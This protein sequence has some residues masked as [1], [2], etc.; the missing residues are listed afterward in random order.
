M[1]FFEQ[2]TTD[3]K[4]KLYIAHIQKNTGHIQTVKQH[5]EHVAQ[6]AQKFACEPLKEIAYTGGLL[7]DVGKYQKSFQQKIVG[8]QNLQVDH[9]TCGA[10]AAKEILNPAGLI[11]RYCIAGHHGGIPNGGYFNDTDDM[12]SLQGRE[13]KKLEDFS[14]YKK[15]LFLTQNINT[16]E[17]AINIAK[18]LM[19]DCDQDKKKMI[20]KFAFMTR[21]CYSCLVDADSLD[22]EQF[23]SDIKR[24]TVKSNFEE[25]L[26]KVTEK[27]DSFQ[28]ITELQ[29]AR[30]RIQKQAYD[31]LTDD[32]EVYLM[33]M[34][35]GSGKTLCSIR[36]ALQLAKKIGK[37]RVIYI[38]PYNSII[39]QTADTFEELFGT[40]AAILRHQSTYSYDE[41]DSGEENYRK[42]DYR[43]MMKQ[44]TENWDADF[45][46]TTAVQFFE[47]IYSNRRSRLR[48]LHN[49]AESILVFDEAHMMPREYLQ[50]CL[51]AVAYLS[52]YFKSTVLFLTA[53][54]PDFRRLIDKYTIDNMKIVE[55]IQ[56]RNEFCRFQRCIYQSMGI[57]SE[58]VLL[59]H[60]MNAAS[61]LVVLNNRK[62]VQKLYKQCN[63]RHKYHLSTYMTSYDRARVITNIKT[64]LILLEE[65]YPKRDHVPSERKIV[66]FSTSLIEAGVDLDFDSAFRELA[67]LDNILQTGGRCNREGKR[68]GAAT[69]IFELDSGQSK[70]PDTVY[71]AI[72]RGLLQKYEDIAVSECIAEYYDKLFFL[73]QGELEKNA[74]YQY[75]D[76]IHSIPFKDYSFQMIKDDQVSIVVPENKESQD[77]V[78]QLKYGG[79]SLSLIRK[80]Q[81]YTCSVRRNEFENLLSQHVLCDYDTGVWVLVNPDYYD[82]EMGIIFEAQDYYI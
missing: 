34:P 12:P 44:A 53:T 75:C 60:I 22:T 51:E 47:S 17:H 81:K 36:C 8:D 48:K 63:A 45:I 82:K 49:M 7:H 65:E 67:G 26:K 41:E 31:N 52:R 14:I 2:N 39:S 21:Y 11:I 58:E 43:I 3:L 74:M 76:D 18:F 54:M 15:E 32:G 68:K 57:V 16:V 72:T 62:N 69:Y 23:C 35:T 55:L 66:A 33:N 29:K 61:S 40:D 28:C 46:I 64:D 19:Q 5:C 59:V 70:K 6:L 38:I 27:L 13:K 1:P 9:S 80:L 30:S 42:E 10:I 50:P 25:C 73:N 79:A 24:K 20:D 71:S 56:D 37:K 4:S 77:L 78:E